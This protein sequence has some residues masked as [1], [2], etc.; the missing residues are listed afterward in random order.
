MT[1][2]AWLSRARR[3]DEEIAGLIELRDREKE[4]VLKIT[5]TLS[6][7]VV[8]TTKDPHKFDRLVEFEAEIDRN[9]DIL[10][11][12][13][14]ETNNAIAKLD[15]GRY[16]EVLRLRYLGNKTFE[17]IAVAIHY[18][19]KQTCRIHGRALLMMEEVLRDV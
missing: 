1:A 5:Q 3:L 18:S 17:E 2:K 19:Y 9:I 6:G 10:V 13:K 15:D 16:R 4:R 7:P 8:Q 11:R 12:T 14:T